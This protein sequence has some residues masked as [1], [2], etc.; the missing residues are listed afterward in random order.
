MCWFRWLKRFVHSGRHRRFPA[1]LAIGTSAFTAK[2][3]TFRD[4]SRCQGFSNVVYSRFILLLFSFF[5]LKVILGEEGLIWLRVSEASFP[6]EKGMPGLCWQWVWGFSYHSRKKTETTGQSQG[7][8]CPFGSHLLYTLPI[9]P[10]ARDQSLKIG[11]Q[12][13]FQ[14]QITAQAKHR[15]P[16]SGALHP[17]P[18]WPSGHSLLCG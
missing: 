5:S 3:H 10:P 11:L 18:L 1:R 9:E 6:G 7:P 2:L 16:L 15:L 14:I 12:E 13:T 17:A 8:L 4:A